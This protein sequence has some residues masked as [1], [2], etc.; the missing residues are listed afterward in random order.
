M[1][2][3]GLILTLLLTTTM[4]ALP[5]AA[6]TGA[7]IAV[8]FSPPPPGGCDPQ[9]AILGEIAGAH[10][11]ILVQA[12]VLTA[13]PIVNALIRA[14]ARGINVRVI[15][16]RKQLEHDRNDTY[17][18][19][20]LM[21]GGIL[22]MIDDGVRGIAHNKVIVIDGRSVIT[23]SYNFT[24]SAEHKNAENLLI[25]RNPTLAGEYAQNWRTRASES[26]PLRVR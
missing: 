5:A 15:L 19:A 22:V 1:K 24:W 8:C 25:I 23:G 10:H 17:A 12:Y 11:E 2:K 3:P 6:Q 21:R 4:F 18:A 13:R 14:H 20:R 26:E 16:D 9:A 7:G